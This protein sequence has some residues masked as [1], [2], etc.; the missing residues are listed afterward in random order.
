MLITLNHNNQSYQSNLA[1]PLNLAI[2]L[3]EGPNTVNCFY[4]P[5]METTP[6]VAGDF[7]GST[8]AGGPVNFLNVKLNPHGNGTHTECVGHIAKEPHSINQR[9][10]SYHHIA[11]LVSVYPTRQDSGDRVILRTQIEELLQ[12]GEVQALILRTLPNDEQKLTRHYSG[13]NP[14]YLHHEATQYLV[15]CGIEHLLIDLPSVDREEDSGQ[16]L[17][18]KAFWQYPDKTRNNSTITELI[19]VAESIEDGL[20][21]LNLQIAAFEID[22]SPSKPVIYALTLS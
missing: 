18:H 12:P 5:L 21:L 14:P 9:L 22:V 13:T 15:S 19:Y 7:I 20:Y 11:K 3:R 2:P 6:V 16:L 4:A 10:R 17:S 8:Q 1:H